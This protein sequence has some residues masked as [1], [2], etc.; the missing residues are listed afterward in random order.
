M[1]AF[2]AFVTDAYLSTQKRAVRICVENIAEAWGISLERIRCARSS[3]EYAAR[4]A[5]ICALDNM[6]VK[7]RDIAAVTEADHHEIMVVID[8]RRQYGQPIRTTNWE[9]FA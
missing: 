8:R 2:S 9:A 6:G 3:K 4:D 5:L 7:V 1:N